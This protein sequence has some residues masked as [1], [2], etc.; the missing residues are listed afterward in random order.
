MAGPNKSLGQHWLH[1]R[2]VLSHIADCAELA[3]DDTVLE[4]GPGLGTLTSELLRRSQKVIA[5]EFD[6]ELARKLPGQFPGKNLEVIESDI[7]SFDYST[8]PAGYKVVANVPY[9]ITS[10]I[11]KSLMTASNKPSVAVLLVQK[12]VAERLAAAP[13]DMSILAVSAQ[14]FA[15]VTLGDIVPAKLFT[16][17]PKVDSRVVVLRT[18]TTPLFTDISESEFFRVV[19]AGFS[20]KR[21]KLRSSLSGGLS[22]SKQDAEQL[23]E[24]AAISPD[25]RAEELDL[26]DWYRL[27]K[28]VN[29]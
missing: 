19:K 18:R 11:V 9:Y 28:I 20:A 24:K 23:L 14:L 27:A 15:E 2:S 12:E 25:S 7:L 1:D 21:K 8:L 10:K 16:P 3:A 13:G 4:I 22:I 5:V 29:A 6:R 17:P 26:D